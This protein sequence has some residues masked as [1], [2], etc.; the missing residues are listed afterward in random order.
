MLGSRRHILC[1]ATVLVLASAGA[2]P[3]AQ[4]QPSR[5]TDQEVKH[6]LTR[7]EKNAEQFR[8]SLAEAPDREWNVGVERARNIDRFITGFVDATRRLRAHF[9][10]G[11]VVTARVDEVLRR[12]VTGNE[13]ARHRTVRA[14]DRSRFEL[15]ACLG[16]PCVDL[17][18]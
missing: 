18:G 9:D 8:R 4:P 17:R 12:G 11:Q 10:R 7:I 1:L 3:A 15:C 13:R 14:C 16:R 2:F 5:A 6:L